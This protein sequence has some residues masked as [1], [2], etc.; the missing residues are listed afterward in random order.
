MDAGDFARATEEVDWVVEVDLII[1]KAKVY[2]RTP[3]GQEF[4]PTDIRDVRA[5]GAQLPVESIDS[6]DMVDVKDKAREKLEEAQRQADVDD[7]VMNCFE[8]ADDE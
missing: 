6:M 8:E 7:A 2:G 1:R 4:S 5:N 3:L